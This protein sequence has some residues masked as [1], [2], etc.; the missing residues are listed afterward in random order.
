M[1]YN[2]GFPLG[3]PQYIPQYQPQQNTAQNDTMIWVQG[4][5]GAKSYLVAPNSTVR[6]WDS[7]A[8]TIYIKSADSSG[9]PSMKILDYTVREEQQPQA[10]VIENHKEYVTHEELD[11]FKNEMLTKIE[12]M[13]DDGV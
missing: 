11:S 4:I 10:S 2:N 1:A 12:S 9:M 7:E 8:Q 6:L 13:R 3:Y 5:N